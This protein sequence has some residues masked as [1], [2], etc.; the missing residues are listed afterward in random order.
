MLQETGMQKHAYRWKSRQA[1]A[2][3]NPSQ[4]RVPQGPNTLQL[5]PESHTEVSMQVTLC[6]P[7][8]HHLPVLGCKH[9]DIQWRINHLLI[10]IPELHATI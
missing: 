3:L 7:V 8:Q 4:A 1:Q 9:T 10:N 5:M 2:S 6:T